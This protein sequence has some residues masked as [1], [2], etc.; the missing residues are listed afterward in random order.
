MMQWE[1][2]VRQSTRLL[3]ALIIYGAAL[4]RPQA[5][6]FFANSYRESQRSLEREE[7]SEPHP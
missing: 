2:M 5:R 4:A 6:G 1:Q 3:R 7:E